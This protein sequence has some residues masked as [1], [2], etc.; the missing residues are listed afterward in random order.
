M[1]AVIILALMKIFFYMRIVEKFSPIVTMLQRVVYDLR[2]FLL[3][4]FILILLFSLLLGVLGVGNPNVPGS[5]LTPEDIE[6][7][8]PSSEYKHT[9]LFIGNF[10]NTL[11]MSLGDFDFDASLY[12]EGD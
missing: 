11:R 9:G 3:F 4:Y 6:I 7:D 5:G 1:L 2:I 10:I 12:L 8:D